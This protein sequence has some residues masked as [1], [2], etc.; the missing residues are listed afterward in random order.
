MK[1]ETIIEGKYNS[2]KIFTDK[3][4]QTAVDQ[5]K[6]LC[7]QE[8]IK[9][10][11]IRIMSDVH[12]GK[13]CVVG[14]TMTIKDKAVPNLLGVDL[15]CG[16][17]VINLGKMDIDLPDMN[18]KIKNQI[19]SGKNIHV[20]AIARM[21]ELRNLKCYRELR[22]T[23]KFERSIG[24]CGGGNHF[25]ELDINPLDGS[26]YIV[27][28]S[29]SRNLGH[30]VAT[31]YQDL[32]IDLCR[33]K[34]KYFEE[35]AN[36]IKDYKEQGRKSE[37]AKALKDLDE[38]Y[39]NSV[40][41]IPE[42]LCYLSGK[43][44]EDYLFDVNIC[45][46]YASLNRKTIAKQIFD[47]LNISG[48][49]LEVFETVHNYIDFSGDIP[50]L[51]KGAVSAKE[52]EILIIPMNMRD[53]SL[54]CRGKGNPDWNCSAPHGAGRLMSRTSARAKLDMK[55]YAESMSEIYSTSVCES[56]LDEAPGAYKPM[57]EIV[58]RI[59]DTVEIIS[60]IKPIYNFKATEEE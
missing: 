56:T 58:E 19:P 33:G 21:P 18:Y 6:I 46:Q 20:S 11:Q 48:E 10:S 3:I 30:Q 45:Q 42:D 59:G 47:I 34:D 32:A 57:E 41:S 8:F 15:S 55:E 23:S 12:A 16:V 37:I 25:I 39:K 28:H 24:S 1:Y 53:G 2:A 40:C 51:R 4:E 50:I 54:I 31:Y 38:S 49:N 60:H 29:G 52:G 14:F 17:L 35:K 22:D 43:Y 26:T 27:I 7:D 5:I 36:I 13:G 9:G 44:L